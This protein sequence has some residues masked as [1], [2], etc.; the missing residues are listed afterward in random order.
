MAKRSVFRDFIST[1]RKYWRTELP[2]VRPVEE[3]FGPMMPKASTFYAG[4]APP[5][6]MHVFVNF[7]HSSKAWEVGRFTV[8][9]VLSQHQG[10]PESWGGPFV[11]DDGA[12]FTE[13]IYR[14]SGLLGCHKD[15]WWHLNQDSSPPIVTEAWRPASYVDYEVVLSET[16]IDVTRDVREA[17]TKLGVL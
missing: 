2:E 14:I 9:V 13:G 10:A 12:S 8:N 11:P 4:I 1:L 17:L 7:Q 15:K 16:A 3:S 6:G 5:L